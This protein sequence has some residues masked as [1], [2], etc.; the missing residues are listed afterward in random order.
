MSERGTLAAALLVLAGGMM[1]CGAAAPSPTSS[2]PPSAQPAADLEP[3]PLPGVAGFTAF[4]DVAEGALRV[5]VGNVG[6]ADAA[7]SSVTVAF[8]YTSKV[9]SGAAPAIAAGSA[10][11]VPV[12]LPQPVTHDAF[13]FTITVDA[14]RTVDEVSEANNYGEGRCPAGSG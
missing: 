5:T 7:A 2:A 8:D 10:T 9:G 4:C 13:D 6:S 1:G 3:V 11:V 14:D 12:A